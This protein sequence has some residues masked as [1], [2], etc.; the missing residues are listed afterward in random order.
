MYTLLK[1]WRTYK[2]V[3]MRASFIVAY[4]MIILLYTTKSVKTRLICV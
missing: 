3:T 4:S 1:I 2:H